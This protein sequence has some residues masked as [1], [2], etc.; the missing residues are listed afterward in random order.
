MPEVQ[1][2]IKGKE[3]K[4]GVDS[5]PTARELISSTDAIECPVF[6]NE[7]TWPRINK[8]TSRT[9]VEI[10]TKSLSESLWDAHVSH[11]DVG[12]S[13]GD[14]IEGEESREGGSN[15][16]GWGSRMHTEFPELTEAEGREM[17]G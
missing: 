2:E 8:F 13:N 12:S 5:I 16:G 15:Y 4:E 9:K 6:F 3:G 17:R 11:H 7:S 10:D 14:E 1:G